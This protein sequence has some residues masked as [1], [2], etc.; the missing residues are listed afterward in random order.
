MVVARST[1]STDVPIHFFPLRGS[2]AWFTYVMPHGPSPWNWTTVSPFTQTKC[3]IPAGHV[4]YVPAGSTS[5]FVSS[6]VSPLPKWNVPEMIV[7]RSGLGCVCGRILYP[8]GAL[9]RKTNGPSLVGSPSCPTNLAP[10][11]RDG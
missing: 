10:G 7:T 8:S 4:P 6:H 2:S 5:P 3:F 9:T 11:G 1:N